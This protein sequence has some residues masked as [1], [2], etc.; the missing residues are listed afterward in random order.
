[1]VMHVNIYDEY[2]ISYLTF[3]IDK[4]IRDC[5]GMMLFGKDMD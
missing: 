4:W 1:M 2:Y 5:I 3:T